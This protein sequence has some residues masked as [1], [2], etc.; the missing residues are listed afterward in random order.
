MIIFSIII[1]LTMI[2]TRSSPD[3]SG[4]TLSLLFT[5]K[6]NPGSECSSSFTTDKEDSNNAQIVDIG[7]CRL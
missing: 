1:K 3:Y 4:A 2:P 5:T 6:I 7:L